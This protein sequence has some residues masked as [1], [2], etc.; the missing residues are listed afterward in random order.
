MNDELKALLEEMDEY[1]TA[2]KG[3]TS[4]LTRMWANKLR[5]IVDLPDSLDEENE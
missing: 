4:T 3:L 5:R 1:A 2:S